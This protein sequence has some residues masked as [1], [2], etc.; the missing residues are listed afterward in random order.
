MDP[1]LS[2]FDSGIVVDSAVTLLSAIIQTISSFQLLLLLLLLRFQSHSYS[3]AS[4]L[5]SDCLSVCLP[6]CRLTLLTV[7]LETEVAVEEP[8]ERLCPLVPVRLLLVVRL[9]CPGLTATAR[10]PAATPAAAAVAI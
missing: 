9:F 5:Y 3:P 4:K 6:A 7:T 2:F 8:R 10:A 1:L